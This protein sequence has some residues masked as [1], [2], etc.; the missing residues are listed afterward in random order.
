MVW[1]F[2]QQMPDLAMVWIPHLLEMIDIAP[3]MDDR[4]NM[5]GDM[6]LRTDLSQSSHLIKNHPVHGHIL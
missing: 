2:I 3:G 5:G 6:K 4:I 1:V